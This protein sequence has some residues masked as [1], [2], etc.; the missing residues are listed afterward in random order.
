[1]CSEPLFSPESI[2]KGTATQREV[3]R[4]NAVVTRLREQL[5]DRIKI[6][7]PDSGF[8]VS[9]MVRV[10][11]Q[12][13][14][15]R[16]LHFAEAGALDFRSGYGLA[17]ITMARCIYETVACYLDFANKLEALLAT[18]DLQKIH[19]FVHNSSFA[20]RAEHLIGIAGTEDVRATSILTQIDRMKKIRDEIRREYDHLCEFTHPNAFGACQYFGNHDAKTDVVTFSSVGHFPDEDCRWVM[21]ATHLL[22]H[23]KEVFDRVERA[24]P[25]LSE[26]GERLKS[27]L[28]NAQPK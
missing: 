14:L 10:Y 9:N 20:T 28:T 27:K 26:K 19:D 1:M 21:V 3:D 8:R 11:N 16:C 13:F 2:P 25:A 15:R 12:S 7:E 4:V 5:V 23:F 18:D 6:Q 24:L 22:E 17:A